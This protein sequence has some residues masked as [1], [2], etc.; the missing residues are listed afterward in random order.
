MMTAPDIAR[1]LL[2]EMLGS[3]FL[4]T[5]VVGSGVMG[6]RLAG[7]NNAI[8]LLANS[9]ATGGALIALITSF[10]PV[11]GAHFNPAVTLFECAGGRI[12]A[13]AAMLYVPAQITGA[14]VGVVVAHAMFALPLLQISA[15]ERASA[16]EF[17]GEFVATFGL[18]LTIWGT[19]RARPEA[20]PTTVA[21]YIV[22]AYWFTSSTSFANPAVTIARALSDTFAGIAPSSLLPFLAAQLLAT[23]AA[24][25]LDRAFARQLRPE[26]RDATSPSR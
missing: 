12:T 19:A 13:K 6:E 20:M 5:A 2:A 4:L 22:A 17:L 9:L 18:L 16:G 26:T 23:G 3:A 21:A 10:A 7:G 14:I 24:L 25:S 15:H 1:R 11:S 8:A